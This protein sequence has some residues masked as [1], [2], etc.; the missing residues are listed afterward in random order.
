[1]SNADPALK[2][3]GYIR[4]STSKQDIGPEVQIAA[5]EAEAIRNGWSL[6]IYRE[7][8]ASA[9][10]LKNRPMLARAL[11]DLKAGTFD[12]LAVSKLDRL[13]RSVADFSGILE[14]ASRQRWALICLDLGIDTSTITG[15]AMAQVTCTFA[16]MERKKI[17]ER[18][19][20]G[21]AKIKA[22]TGKH[23]GRRS[24]L[25]EATVRQIVSE[26]E[27]GASLAR[28]AANLNMA[29]VP[30]AAGGKWY[31][32]TVRQVLGSSAAAQLGP[33]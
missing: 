33:K 30:T 3:I 28:I 14:T 2:V 6:T 32:S 1:M 7:D 29:S 20:D 13:S 18:T 4:V 23:M 5:L 15:A 24:V 21:M 27:N 31:A 11:A 19:K 22:T 26:R 8:A 10:S 17:A 16:E 25:P 12:A 9:K